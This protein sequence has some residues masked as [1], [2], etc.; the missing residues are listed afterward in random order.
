M[1]NPTAKLSDAMINSLLS[2]GLSSPADLSQLPEMMIGVHS[3]NAGQAD[4]PAMMSSPCT[5]AGGE[6]RGGRRSVIAA[7]FGVVFVFAG[8]SVCRCC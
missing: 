5:Q 1:K 4:P 2:D 3:H 8:V 7:T 6:G